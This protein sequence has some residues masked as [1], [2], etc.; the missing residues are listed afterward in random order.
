MLR[1][2]TQG[3]TDDEV[4]TARS[5]PKVW[6]GRAFGVVRRLP[7]ALHLLAVG[8]GPGPL[9]VEAHDAELQA[10][11]LHHLAGD[12][13]LH[14]REDRLLHAS[15]GLLREQAVQ[16]GVAGAPASQPEGTSGAQSEIGEEVLRS[17]Q[18]PTADGERRRQSAENALG[19]RGPPTGTPE[20]H[21]PPRSQGMSACLS[22]RRACAPLIDMISCLL[23]SSRLRE[24]GRLGGGA[25][26][27]HPSRLRGGDDRRGGSRRRS[28]R[29]G[30][31][32]RD[33]RQAV[34]RTKPGHQIGPA[35]SGGVPGAGRHFRAG[36]RIRS[37]GPR[38]A[39]LP[40]RPS[41]PPSHRQGP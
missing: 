21:R 19:G 29:S 28:S 5:A 15:R 16:R 12:E 23:A 30:N 38:R 1:C 35:G 36:A 27:L 7:G 14:L 20:G 25:H 39:H 11:V 32:A 37:G 6:Q 24:F 31:G 22:A 41:A 8:A 13:F 26:R 40:P 4:S 3:H 18:A 10:V 9:A 17:P 2:P 34:H 33:H